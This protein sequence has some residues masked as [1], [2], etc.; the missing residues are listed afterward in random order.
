MFPI[1]DEPME[2]SYPDPSIH[3]IPEQESYRVTYQQ[4]EGGTERAKTKLV[5][6][7][8][9]SYN[10]KQKRARVTYWQCT[11]RPKGNAC[12]AMV[13]QRGSEYQQSHQTHNHQPTPG[14]GTAAKVMASVKQ[15]AIADLFRPAS[16]IVNEVNNLKCREIWPLIIRE[17]KGPVVYSVTVPSIRQTFLRTTNCLILRR[18]T[19]LSRSTLNKIKWSLNRRHVCF[20]KTH[21]RY[22]GPLIF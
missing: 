4:I 21:N 15:K 22:G 14:A 13:V 16:A 19:T 17:L 18:K 8:G 20:L 6:S 12:K 10:I 7:D 2:A 5:D 11:V 3:S 1:I 9:Y